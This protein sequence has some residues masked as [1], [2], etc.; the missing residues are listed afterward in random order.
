[1]VDFIIHHFSITF[2]VESGVFEINNMI[3]KMSSLFN[4]SKVNILHKYKISQY[5]TQA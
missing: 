1:M 3:D 5:F 2:E 4:I